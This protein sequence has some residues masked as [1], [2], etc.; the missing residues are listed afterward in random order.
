[1]M[2][3]SRRGSRSGYIVRS[4]ALEPS[5]QT[6]LKQGSRSDVEVY[7]NTLRE[8]DGGSLLGQAD[9]PEGEAGRPATV[10][11]R[12]SLRSRASSSLLEPSGVSFSHGYVLWLLFKLI[13]VSYLSR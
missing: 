7:C 9:R 1:M 13:L 2:D 10:A 3:Y 12:S 5:D 6:E 11:S 8:G 4:D